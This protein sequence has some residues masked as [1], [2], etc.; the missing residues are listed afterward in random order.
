M[1][2]AQ[3]KTHFFKSNQQKFMCRYHIKILKNFVFSWLMIFLVNLCDITGGDFQ[4]SS[5]T[6]TASL[7]WTIYL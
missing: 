1:F 6:A 2:I 7:L 4:R 5:K 3:I